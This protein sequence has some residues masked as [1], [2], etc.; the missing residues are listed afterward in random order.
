MNILI[1]NKEVNFDRDDF[2]ML[3]HGYQK[4]GTSHFTVCLMA[5]LHANKNKVLF[6]SAYP[7]AKEEFRNE[8]N[9]QENDAIV[10]YSGEEEVFIETIKNT[11]DLVERVVLVKNIKNYS[12]KL[13]D[14]V[15]DL[16]LVVFSGNLDECQ[17]T[18]ELLKKEFTTKIFFSQSFK[19]P[20]DGL[21]DLPKYYA[22][23]TSSKYSGLITLGGI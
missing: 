4:T 16:R 21:E 22:K 10:I 3:I 14:S 7:E 13:F 6:F 1:N 11:P 15:K 8:I 19:Y 18:D 23:I 2:P 17:F 9:H 12:R 5:N 20:Q